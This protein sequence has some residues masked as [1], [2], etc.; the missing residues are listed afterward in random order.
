MMPEKFDPLIA[1]LELVQPGLSPE[2]LY[3]R[4]AHLEPGE[5]DAIIAQAYKQ[6]LAELLYALLLQL[7][8][9]HGLEIPQK[10]RLHHSFLSTT[11]KNM[12]I[13]H[14]TEAVFSALHKAGIPA[15]GLKGIYL[16]ENIYGDIGARSMNDIDI[17]VKRSDLKGAIEVLKGLGYSQTS[18]FSLDD[19][20]ADTKHVP[21]MQKS[22][23][24]LLEVHWT[25]L[26]ENE[27][28]TIDPDALW[29]RNLPAKIANVAA[30]ALG[31][32]DL[33][34]HLCLHLTYQHYLQLGLRGLLDVALVI[35]KF[36]EQIDWQKL[37]RI[38]KSWRAERVTALTMKLVETQLNVP[39]PSEVY[40]DLLPKPLE[41]EILQDARSVL[42]ERGEQGER[43]TPDLVQLNDSRNLYA[44]LKISLQR[45]FIPRIALART[46]NV[47]PNSPKIIGLYWVRVK[48]LFRNYW[49]TVRRLQV[50]EN[51][52]QPA[53][54]KAKKSY[55]L[56]KW[57][58]K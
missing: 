8:R 44:K 23:S 29:Q 11:A 54:D 3:L 35:Q 16:L 43:L 56:H 57:M 47:P 33:I 45:V 5:W 7:N 18:Y 40:N 41:P 53:L 31:V 21:P 6:D 49:G 19:L 51:S 24:P 2:E 25:L 10:E 48:Y 36:R 42:L 13:L 32:E 39:I 38:A 46:Y 34:L 20:N 58:T 17:L 28:F 9:S 12:L 14:D 37:V 52:S 50:G 30:L 27:P 4:A 22:G 1:L 55:S 26:E 15:A